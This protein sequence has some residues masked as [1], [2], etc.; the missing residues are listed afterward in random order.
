[1]PVTANISAEDISQRTQYA[2]GGIGKWYWDKRDDAILTQVA[3]AAT[4]LDAGCGEGI[5]T[6]KIIARFPEAKVTG[7]DV[8]PR[9]V[10]ICE[11]YDLPVKEC[12][13][14]NLPFENNSFDVC[15]LIEVIEHLCEPEKALMEL[16]RVAKPGGKII[17]VFPIDW[18]MWLARI[19]CLRWKEAKFDPL[20]LRQWSFRTLNIA[21]TATEIA[22]IYKKYLPF[23]PLTLHGL[24]VGEKAKCHN[25][26]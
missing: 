7:V 4:I 8:D 3:G 25:T 22:P 13:L 6:E 15:L 12:S 21:M 19:A 11:Q 17:V 16:T 1:M 5:T 24:M 10:K 20:H 26:K 23:F 2:K 18:T 9:N 14:Y